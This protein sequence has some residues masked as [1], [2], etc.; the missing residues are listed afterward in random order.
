MLY[1]C[2]LTDISRHLLYDPDLWKWAKKNNF[3][4]ECLSS[5]PTIIHERFKTL[6]SSRLY[7]YFVHCYVLFFMVYFVCDVEY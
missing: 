3:H 2:S 7:M 4:A 1:F 5:N 6:F